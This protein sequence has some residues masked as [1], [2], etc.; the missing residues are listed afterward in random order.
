MGGERGNSL[1]G[2]GRVA[3]DERRGWETSGGK[4]SEERRV[5]G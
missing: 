4:L 5:S 3:G 2:S 1:I